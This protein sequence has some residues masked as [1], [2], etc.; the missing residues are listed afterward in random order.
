MDPAANSPGA[1][2][3]AEERPRLTLP[4]QMPAHDKRHD[5]HGRDR[6]QEPRTQA[7]SFDAKQGEEDKPGPD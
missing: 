1:C 3:H 6:Q 4:R 7:L 2:V 5:R